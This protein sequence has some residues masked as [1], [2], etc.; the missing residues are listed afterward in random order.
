MILLRVRQVDKA[1]GSYPTYA[2]VRFPYPLFVYSSPVPLGT[3][4]G[5]P[6]QG[7]SDV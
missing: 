7:V 6:R 1:V 4:G 2:G 5:Q 3:M